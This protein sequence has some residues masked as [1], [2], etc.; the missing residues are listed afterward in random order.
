MAGR[1]P[2]A[3]VEMWGDDAAA[4]ADVDEGGRGNAPL[5][6]EANTVA[7]GRVVVV[8]TGAATTVTGDA[9]AG[10]GVPAEAA[11]PTPG[12][13]RANACADLLLWAGSPGLRQCRCCVLG[14]V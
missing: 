8:V 2:A 3:A 4:C 14:V 6:V 12:V 5:D 1:F 9:T 10:A 7:G 13:G 11:A